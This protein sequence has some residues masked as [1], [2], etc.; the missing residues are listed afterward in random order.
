MSFG[1]PEWLWALLLL[2]ALMLLFLQA[3]RKAVRRLQEF[4][5]PKLLRQLS[6]NVDRFRR[7]TRV[8]LQLLALGLAFV[9]LA[10][11]RWGYAFEEAKRKGIDL[12]IAVD[13]SRS[14]LSNDVQPNR[15][16]RVKLAAQDLVSELAGDRVGLIAFAGRAFVQ[17]PLTIDYEACVE[18]INDLDTKTIPE[19][20]TNISEAITLASRTFGKSAEGNRALVIF[21][22]GEELSGDAVKAAKGAAEAGIRI[23]TVGVG[24]PQGSLIPL[25]DDG[26]T[27]FVKDPGGQVV[28]SRLDE[29][30]LREIA[31]LTGG[32]YLHLEN[33]PETMKA[34]TSGGL[35]KLTA[36][37]MDVRV[38]R[39]PIE[40]YHW[41]LSAAG[42]VLALSTVISE[43][44]RARVRSVQPAPVRLASPTA[45]VAMLL[46]SFTPAFSAVNGLNLYANGRYPEAYEA[47]QQDLKAHPGS[48]DKDKI[49]FDAGAA[50]YKMRDFNKAAEAFSQALLSNDGKIQESSHYNL[51]RTLEDRA[52]MSRSDDEALTDL[53]NAKTHYQDVLKLNPNNPAAKANLEEVK[54][55]IERLKQRRKQKPPPQA[56]QNQKQNQKKQDQQQN[57]SDQNQSQQNQQ[58]GSSQKEQQKSAQNQQGQ[59]QQQQQSQANNGGSSGQSGQQQQRQQQQ[60]GQAQAKNEHQPSQQQGDQGSTPTPSP[61][62]QSAAQSSPSPGEG[63]SDQQNQPDSGA[64]NRPPEPSPSPGQ[65]NAETAPSPAEENGGDS[66]GTGSPSPTPAGSPQKKFAGEIKGASQNPS[67]SPG[68]RQNAAEAEPDDG[69]MTERQAE[70]LLESMK[71]EEARVQLDER[72]AARRVYKD[73]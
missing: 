54:K 5:A 67:P 68:E 71:D 12:L 9:A 43:R 64:E 55:K 18:A 39:R 4:I 65:G 63:Q 31:E 56:Q 11:P 34:L 2:P 21:S 53:E 48:P 61:G 46:L 58:S 22:D 1:E 8:V 29:Q 59:N 41:P 40:R 44:K 10:Q 16:Q 14:M 19:G 13:T 73:W 62:A 45:T 72:R 69:Q 28:K 47:F 15:L 60:Q 38:S 3:E 52:D 36:Q 57:K 30:R 66:A 26:S 33:G 23:F 50:A 6:A 42:I 7:A 32:F 37:E 35:G 49:Q 20:G 24:T 25:G 70:R 51:G 17:A 27:D